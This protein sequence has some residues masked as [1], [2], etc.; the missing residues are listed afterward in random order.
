[1]SEVLAVFSDYAS[2]VVA[3]RRVRELR[4]ISCETLD[5]IGGLSKGMSS[6]VLAPD[7]SRRLTVQS[8]KWILDGLA[9]KCQIVSDD[10]ALKQ[11]NGRMIARNPVMVR[12]GAVVVLLSR[13]FLSKI[14]RKGAL[15]RN[16][17][18]KRR[19]AAARHAARAR[20]SGHANG[21]GR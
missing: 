10:E 14:G 2:L 21:G 5:E 19:K 9:C 4:G 7:G 3:L 6:K 15:A 11:I 17:Q 12:D 18:R 13:K 8:L 16:A 1:M 20:W